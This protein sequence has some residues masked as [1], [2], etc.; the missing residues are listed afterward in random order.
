[1]MNHE[2]SML[3][4]YF[5]KISG[6]INKNY[7]N[8]K[9]T[10]MLSNNNLE[11]ITGLFIIFNQKYVRLD[12]QKSLHAF[13]LLLGTQIILSENIKQLIRLYNLNL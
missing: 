1:M 10:L 6:K 13:Q 11:I 12:Y 4:Q 5:I 3:T 2:I 8:N 9:N 7:K